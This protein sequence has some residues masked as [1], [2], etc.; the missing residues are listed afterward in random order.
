MPWGYISHEMRPTKDTR[1]L[2]Q[3]CQEPWTRKVVSPISHLKDVP[4]FKA[5]S[6]VKMSV[7][8]ISHACAEATKSGVCPFE[9]TMLHVALSTF[10]AAFGKNLECLG[11]MWMSWQ[12]MRVR[13]YMEHDA[14]LEEQQV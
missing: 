8:G 9:L 7:T 11:S 6:K 4:T 10:I 14:I 2:Q 1:T 5:R 3:V 12:S 13:G